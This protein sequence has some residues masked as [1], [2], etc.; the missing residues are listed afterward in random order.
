MRVAAEHRPIRT[1]RNLRGHGLRGWLRLHRQRR[2]ATRWSGLGRGCRGSRQRLRTV[3]SASRCRASRW[4]QPR[5][6]KLRCACRFGPAPSALCRAAGRRRRRPCCRGKPCRPQPAASPRLPPACRT[7]SSACRSDYRN[8]TGKPF[9]STPN[10]RPSGYGHARDRAAEVRAA[11]VPEPAGLGDIAP[12][13]RVNRIQVAGALGRFRVIAGRE[14]HRIAADYGCGHDARLRTAAADLPDRVLRV[15]VEFPE[16]LARGRLERVTPAV[17]AGEDHLRLASD[18]P[19]RGRG[20]LAVQN[21]AAGVIA[22]P[23]DL[24]GLLIDSDERRGR[25][26]RA[27]FSW[28]SSTPL[29]V[30]T[31]IRSPRA[32]RRAGGQVCAGTRPTGRSCRASR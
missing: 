11:D 25:P 18:D 14:V 29:P 32:D 24:A 23:D 17:A 3:P 1:R 12:L 30:Q 13:R 31:K 4:Q 7:A 21:A 27:G 22:L 9:R 20:P 26:G 6:R 10:S 28:S 19:V 2:R 8:T 16:W 15:Q 5:C